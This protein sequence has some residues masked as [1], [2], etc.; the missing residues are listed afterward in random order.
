MAYLKCKNNLPHQFKIIA[1]FNDI[2]VENCIICGFKVRWQKDSKGRTHNLKYLELHAGDFCQPN[3]RTKSL[4]YKIYH[5]QYCYIRI[6]LDCEGV[7]HHKTAARQE[8]RIDTRV[9]PPPGQTY[10]NA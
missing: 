8:L 2:Q 5:P 6:C 1:D 4:Y 3:G 9:K 10:W 7:C